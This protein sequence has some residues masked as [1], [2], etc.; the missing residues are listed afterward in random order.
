MSTLKVNTIQDTSGNTRPSGITMIDNWIITSTYNTNSVANMTSN[1][2]RES[3]TLSNVGIIGS[4]M[5]ESS[6]VFTFPTTGIY[7]VLGQLYAITNGG[8]R[9]YMGMMPQISTDS[10]SNFTTLLTGYQNGY[11]NNAYVFLQNAKLVDITNTST[12]KMRFQTQM[13]D[14][15]NVVGSDSNKTTGV[16]FI[17]VGDT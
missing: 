2:A 9:T 1:W 7:L 4:G 16:T 5:T 3:A 6:G 13:S 12:H 14:N 11:Q 17:R 15:T 10:G 8:G